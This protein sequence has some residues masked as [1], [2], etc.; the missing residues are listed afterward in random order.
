MSEHETKLDNVLRQWACSVIVPLGGEPTNEHEMR[1]VKNMM[2][3][4]LKLLQ[5]CQVNE[6][7]AP[8]ED[9]VG[10]LVEAAEKVYQL[11]DVMHAAGPS[12]LIVALAMIDLDKAAEKVR[13]ESASKPPDVGN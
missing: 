3:H 5:M 8:T 4:G 11:R 13:Q 12:A 2:Y 1:A 7:E 10:E 6:T 9:G